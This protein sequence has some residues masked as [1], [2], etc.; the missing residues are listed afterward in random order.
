MDKRIQDLDPAFVISSEDLLHVSQTG[1]DKKVGFNLLKDTINADVQGLIDQA[2]II[3]S[4]VQD[5][6]IEVEINKTAAQQAAAAAGDSES[7][8]E[9]SES[10]AR[11]SELNAQDSE[12]MARLWASK[13]ENELVEDEYYSAFHYM[14]KSQ[15]SAEE[16]LESSQSAE[17]SAERADTAAVLVESQIE[18]VTKEVKNYTG[19]EVTVSFDL[20]VNPVS[21]NN[22]EVFIDGEY[23]SKELYSVNNTMLL[24]NTAPPLGSNIEILIGP[25]VQLEV[26]DADNIVYGSRSVARALSDIETNYSTKIELNTHNHNPLA[27]PELSSFISSEADRAETARDAA[28][29]NADVY[30]DIASG[31]AAVADGE[32]FQ[33]VSADGLELIRYRRDSSSTQHEVG[34]YP[35]AASVRSSATPKTSHLVRSMPNSAY[36]DP[37]W[38]PVMEAMVDSEED[39]PLGWWKTGEKIPLGTRTKD[40]I[41]NWSP[42]SL[43][44]A[45]FVGNWISAMD[46]AYLF[47]DYAGTVPVEEYGDPVRLAVC[48]LV[49][50]PNADR[51]A[52]PIVNGGFNTDLSGWTLPGDN[53]STWDA[54]RAH[55]VSG[56]NSTG[57]FQT[58]QTV[59]GRVYYFTADAEI[60]T[61]SIKD[62]R[63]AQFRVVGGTIFDATMVSS[64]AGKISAH[65]LAH[66]N[67]IN[68]FLSTTSISVEGRAAWFDNVEGF[69][70]VEGDYAADFEGNPP[71]YTEH[72]DGLPCI[73]WDSSDNRGFLR[74]VYGL[75]VLDRTNF[76]NGVFGSRERDD[77]LS[78]YTWTNNNRIGLRNGAGASP[79]P[80][81]SLT[82][83]TT[84]LGENIVFA[85]GD[86]PRFG[87]EGLLLTS[88]WGSD[89]PLRLYRN[90]SLL[91]Q[92]GTPLPAG[93]ALPYLQHPY[94]GGRAERDRLGDLTVRDWFFGTV[95]RKLTESERKKALSFVS[96]GYT[97]N[98]DTRVFSIG[99]SST[100][101]YGGYPKMLDL[102]TSEHTRVS[103]DV[104][105]ATIASRQNAWAAAVNKDAA[106]WVFIMIGHNDIVARP[107]TSDLIE[108]LQSL[109]SEVRSAVPAGCKIVLA[110]LTPAKQRYINLLGETDGEAAYQQWLDYNEAIMGN[111][112]TPIT[113]VDYRMDAHRIAL[114]VGNGYLKTDYDIGDGIHYGTV[115]RQ[116]VADT[117]VDLLESRGVTV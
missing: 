45:G 100:A 52:P 93:E 18:A 79:S 9:T 110:E 70:F 77:A 6:S 36:I 85:F 27:H 46:K 59:P 21:K 34:R 84:P 32:Q 87:M 96:R 74:A 65:I 57:I 66:G 107:T 116:I 42:A 50:T 112:S 81:S 60:D 37:T 30:P 82:G 108:R 29:V 67:S 15:L 103:L 41:T 19:D 33:V 106:Q 38:L 3:L 1:I 39:A 23:I 35:S 78:Y 71:I 56:G 102:L 26:G 49:G 105:G 12:T 115:A 10:N 7:A 69:Q 104:G 5:T 25:S 2:G 16:A 48:R 47:Q 98:P 92:S 20:G 113:G 53:A 28:F 40:V 51:G 54:G 114:D 58:I 24:F 89:E 90:G 99:A 43:R 17:R 14:K 75:N 94:I 64:G 22:T 80:S 97:P 91:A 73:E 68:L 95:T 88:Y 76:V 111:G 13:P 109:V 63:S 8:A 83:F 117:L 11:N 31:R 4:E 61:S 55:V 72:E 62:G 101:E 86:T 44:D